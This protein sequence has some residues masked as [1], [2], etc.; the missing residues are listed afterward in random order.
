MKKSILKFILLIILIRGFSLA[1]EGNS[2][3]SIPVITINKAL[4]TTKPPYHLSYNISLSSNSYNVP[5]YYQ[6]AYYKLEHFQHVFRNIPN[7]EVLTYF[8]LYHY[9]EFLKYAQSLPEYNDFM[10]K[11]HER[12]QT[13]KKFRKATACVPGFEYRGGLFRRA[14]K[15]EV[16]KFHE[17]IA[18]E[19]KRIEKLETTLQ[20]GG[21]VIQGVYHDWLARNRHVGNQKILEAR[22][23]A[24]HELYEGNVNALQDQLNSEVADIENRVHE[25]ESNYSSNR[26]VKILTPL[27]RTCAAQAIKETCPITAFQLTDFSYAVTDLLFHSMGVLYEVSYHAAKGISKGVATVA[28]IDHWKNIVVDTAHLA[29]MCIDAVG[30]EAVFDTSYA[31]ARSSAKPD[32]MIQFSQQYCLQKREELDA[33]KAIAQENYNKLKEM[34][35]Q[36]VVENGSEIG[37]ILILDTLVLNAVGAGVNSVNKTFINKLSGLTESGAL[38]TEQCAVEV[39]GVGKL[40][41]EEGPEVTAKIGDLVKKDL[42]ACM[43]GQNAANQIRKNICPEKWVQEIAHKIRNVGD[44][45]LDIMEKAGGHTLELHVGQ[46]HEDLLLRAKNTDLGMVSSFNSKSIAIKSIKENLKNNWE[47]ILLWLQNNP[48]MDKPKTFD[49]YHTHEIG[50][51]VAKGKKNGLASLNKS[52]VVLLPDFSSEFGFEMR[53]SFPI[54]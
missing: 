27:V 29:A 17:F 51:G 25:L 31:L 49:F 22:I 11:L 23:D 5:N 10:K 14:R 37:T 33:F 50:K 32:A 19:Y 15:T 35:W 40:I 6:Y 34:P 3:S 46:T 52:R 7:D 8:D 2:Y 28:S 16:S 53:T 47:E 18:S 9:P 20:L 54:A 41:I 30:Q 36:E 26:Y 48:S 1:G 4:C 38:F 13:D 43:D 12:I 44:D 24:V 45:I 21:Y 39:A 42:I